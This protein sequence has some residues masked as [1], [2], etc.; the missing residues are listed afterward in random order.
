SDKV[1]TNI[2]YSYRSLP[3]EEKKD[4]VLKH[5]R[6]ILLE[7]HWHPLARYTIIKNRK[8]ITFKAT[9]FYPIWRIEEESNGKR[10]SKIYQPKAKDKGRR[11]FYEGGFDA[12]FLHGYQQVCKAYNDLLAKAKEKEDEDDPAAEEV[13]LD[14]II[15]CTG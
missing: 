3:A 11:F 14:E 9:E 5:L 1:W 6:S 13:K 10:F 15:Y 2:E 12:K 7:Q 8:A 4:A